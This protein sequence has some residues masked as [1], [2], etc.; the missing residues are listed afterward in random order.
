MLMSVWKI[1]AW[2]MLSGTYD[3]KHIGKRLVNMAGK[4]DKVLGSLP[5]KR[6]R[7]PEKRK[8]TQVIILF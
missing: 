1:L 2:K 3:W 8:R 6:I 7:F 4:Q 5:L